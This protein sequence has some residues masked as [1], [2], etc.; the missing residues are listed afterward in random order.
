MNELVEVGKLAAEHWPGLTLVTM[1]VIITFKLVRVMDKFAARVTH[2][3]E[4]AAAELTWRIKHQDVTEEKIE[5]IRQLATGAL[6]LQKDMASLADSVRTLR[7]GQSE[8]QKYGGAAMEVLMEARRA[9]LLKMPE[10]R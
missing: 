4:L 3:E 5:E 7:D 6:L 9:G 1:A 2:L 10:P 8:M